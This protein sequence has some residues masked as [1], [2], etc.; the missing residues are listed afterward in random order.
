[1]PALDIN[2]I[3]NSPLITIGVTCFQARDTISQ[4]IQSALDQDWPN[5]ELIIVDDCS[6]DGSDVIIQDKIL[7]INHARLIRHEVNSGPAVSRNTLLANALGEFLVFFDD[8]DKSLPSRVRVQFNTLKAYELNHGTNLVACYASGVRKYPNGY[9][10]NIVA[11]G[12]RPLIPKGEAVV[13]YLL[14]NSRKPKVF[15]GGGTPTC[16]LMARTSTFKLVGG[17]DSTLRRVEDIDF[18]IRLALLGGHFI[19]CSGALYIQ[20]ATQAVDKSPQKNLEAELLLLEKNAT[21]LKS[22]KRYGYSR[23]WFKIRFYHFSGQRIK[24]IISLVFFIIKHPVAGTM[25]FIYSAPRRL[26]HELKMHKT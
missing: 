18:A 15:Y 20:Y 11:I 22:K 3:A 14:F 21:Y 26:F 5:I 12:S 4:A 25:H 8:D 6:T 17:F 16:A 19:G 9:Q 2:M 24:F 13:D 10:F 1:M 7:G 23:D